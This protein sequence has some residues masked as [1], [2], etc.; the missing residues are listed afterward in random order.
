[1]EDI[2]KDARFSHIPTDPRFR[3]M[4]KRDRKVKI[5]KRF[6]SMFNDKRFKLKYTVD[7]RGRPI[8]LTSN[9]H[10]RQFYELDTSESEDDGSGDQER[11]EKKSKKSAKGK[12]N[13][14]KTESMKKYND[15]RK[16][17]SDI[18][19][20]K[21][22][23]K[24]FSNKD[25]KFDKIDSKGNK[26]KSKA[27]MV[28]V[29]KEK[30]K[31]KKSVCSTDKERMSLRNV[32]K[33]APYDPGNMKDSSKESEER[34][35]DKEG[36]ED[37]EDSD[38]DDDD[39]E[40]EEE[41]E[42]EDV[43]DEDDDEEE[44]D[45][46]TEDEETDNR[47][48]QAFGPD[49][50][51]GEGG[52]ESSS[53]E[54]SGLEEEEDE[55]EADDMWDDLDTNAPQADEATNRLAMCNMDWDRIKAQDLFVLLNS[56]KPTAGVIKSVTIYP[57]EY[58]AERM[59]EEGM[60]GPTELVEKTKSLGEDG[61]EDEEEEKG[62]EESPEFRE[63]L[64][65]YQLN[66]L[67][68]FY[69]IVECDSVE[70]ANALYEQL[71]GWEYESSA[72][73]LDLRFV[74]DGMTFDQKPKSVATDM[75]DATVYKPNLFVTTA[76]NQT[77]VDCTW[78]ET[79]RD[80][81]ALTMRDF[82]KEELQEMDVKAYLAS[83]SDD[84]DGANPYGDL[85][86]KPDFAISDGEGSEEDEDKALEKYKALLK[87]VEEK[88]EKK[89][90]KDMEMEI[91]WE[92]GLKET[93][94]DMLKKKE[95]DKGSLTPWEQ[96][97]KKKK[98]KKKVKKQEKQS[99]TIDE[100]GSSDDDIPAG[101]D[102]NDPYFKE[103]LEEIEGKSVKKKKK[104]RQFEED[105]ETANQK[106]EMS[107]LLMDEDDKKQHFSLKGIME[108][109]KKKKK[110]KKLRKK[111]D[112]Q[113]VEDTFKMNVN[114]PRFNAVF[115]SHLYNID[116]SASEF[117]KTKAMQELVEAKVKKRSEKEKGEKP[118]LKNDEE[119]PRKSQKITLDTVAKET[120]TKT[121][122]DASLS[123]LVK[124]VKAKTMQYHQKKSK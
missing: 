105:E 28:S 17:K 82:S 69:A 71:D 104:Q 34:S 30:N 109:E 116:P 42:G 102:M 44:E 55:D 57:S 65:K 80:R 45:L 88:D 7:K 117:K 94:E 119:P 118:S 111:K 87:T 100:A 123:L 93:T 73:K 76:L 12:V 103:G 6:Q 90:E 96:Y 107:L 16:G 85:I 106:A 33:R 66:R 27:G 81:T 75:P 19:M 21:S 110:K 5:D 68:Y 77:K 10:L 32:K 59:K 13:K 15:K 37:Q 9:D 14:A 115:T 36:Q 114:D 35:S 91:T 22:S 64:R 47:K 43:E 58:G 38:D 79:D 46:E 70:T 101:V 83:S 18:E 120:N 84:E 39:D 113:H 40:N 8:N 52:V 1:M 51:R 122:K 11:S 49:L 4:G 20:K 108:Q 53:D 56:F 78:D 23:L 62:D 99:K 48:T 89:E 72:T 63:K 26:S 92:P 74:P 97:L 29:N 50:A 112:E 24:E 31:S 67:K 3:R 54:D 41:K 121:D 25:I 86:E 98:E 2:V 60:K 61:E 95:E 124:S